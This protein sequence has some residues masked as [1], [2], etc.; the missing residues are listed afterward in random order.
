MTTPDPAALKRLLD[1]RPSLEEMWQAFLGKR[2]DTIPLG[3]LAQVEHTFKLGACFAIFALLE[4]L[5]EEGDDGALD[6][7]VVAA[8]LTYHEDLEDEARAWV[9]GMVAMEQ[10][11]LARERAKGN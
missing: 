6:Q 10:A 9:A 1:G 3:L 11:H 8:N 5:Y 2:R 4:T 7:N